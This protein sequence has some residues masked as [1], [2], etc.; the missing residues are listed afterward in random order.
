MRRV[1]PP[2]TA[3]TGSLS[4]RLGRFRA[5]PRGPRPVSSTNVHHV[6]NRGARKLLVFCDDRDR[7]RFLWLLT[8]ATERHGVAVY[9]Y[10][11]L[12]NH[13]HLLV[14]APREALWRAMHRLST[15]YTQQ[16]NRRY[17]LDGALFA[18]RYWS[19]PIETDGRLLATARYIERNALDVDPG[20]PLG[21]YRW[22]SLGATLGR[23][24]A[25][26]FLHLDAVLGYFAGRPEAYLDFVQRDRP[27]DKK[28]R[29][30]LLAPL[31]FSAERVAAAVRQALVGMAGV[32]PTDERQIRLILDREFTPLDA[33]RLAQRYGLSGPGSAR[34]LVSRARKR[35]RTDP[36]FASCLDLA[37]ALLVE[38][39]PV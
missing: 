1:G 36:G 34:A 23:W 37:R 30:P 24:T 9:S 17:G 3:V 2:A 31:S 12:D 33:T 14:H 20:L 16:F 35:A 11:L 5:M 21:R 27:G 8:D 7:R 25:P 38:P 32:G 28:R 15:L 39:E 19:D 13:F 22:S 26:P 6:G 4:V 18:G 10:C 29:D